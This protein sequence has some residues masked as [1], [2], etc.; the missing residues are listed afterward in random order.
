MS[1]ANSPKSTTKHYRITQKSR[2]H[3]VSF[4]EAESNARN[5]LQA[6][7]RLR[8]TGDVSELG[9]DLEDNLLDSAN[10][11]YRS[12]HGGSKQGGYR[13]VVIFELPCK[14]SK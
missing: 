7:A 12:A 8:A 2:N 9:L 4:G 13:R 5:L 6:L 11:A 1:V 10:I 14:L 3:L